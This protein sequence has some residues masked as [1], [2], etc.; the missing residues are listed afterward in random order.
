MSRVL[1]VN[2]VGSDNGAGLS[3]D[4]RLLC[5]TLRIAGVRVKWSKRYTP[6][7]A[8]TLLQRGGALEWWL[9]RFD[10]NVFLERFHPAWFPFARQNV[11]IPNPEWF[12]E[13]QLAQLSG[14]DV[15]FC[16]TQ[17]AVGVF[18]GLGKTTRWVGFTSSDHFNGILAASQPVRALHLAG[19]SID[20]GTDLVV[21]AWRLHPEWPA[22]TVVQRPHV[23]K[24]KLDITPAPN[25]RFLTHRLEDEQI[26]ALQRGHAL[27]VLP[28]EVEGYG[29]TIVEA[30][31]VGAVVVTTNAPPMNELVTRERGVL[32]AVGPGTPTRL[33]VRVQADMSALE[34]AIAQALAW[35]AEVRTVVGMAA[36]EWFTQN[37]ARF[38]SE[39][40]QAVNALDGQDV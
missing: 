3:R 4:A 25:I 40:V 38:R 28:S 15:V 35:P 21:A 10:V 18:N 32:V 2:I 20:K 26:L 34:A 36:R 8:M 22:L 12:M 11:L 19:R 7:E 27:H 33:G 29:Q 5:D 13:E 24:F 31:G 1:T 17:H 16:K 39:F 23:G 9:P 6:R 14:I 30:M 37:D